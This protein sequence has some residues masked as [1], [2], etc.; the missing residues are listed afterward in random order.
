M[1]LVLI[2]V[3]AGIYIG[4]AAPPSARSVL[5][6]TSVAVVCFLAAL[7][8]DGWA[9]AWKASGLGLAVPVVS[10]RMA[11]TKWSTPDIYDE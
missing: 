7:G 5:L 11:A 10:A 6:L 1:L 9:L 8:I 4:F 2:T 3:G